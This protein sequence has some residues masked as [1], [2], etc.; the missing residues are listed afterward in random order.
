MKLSAWDLRLA[1]RAFGVASVAALVALLVIV[2][3]DDGASWARRAAMWGAIAPV[4][5]AVGV[6]AA[7]RVA[8]ARGELLA[9]SA[10]GAQ[11]GR[12]QAGA[13]VGGVVLALAGPVVLSSGFAD[14]SAL[15]PEPIEARAWVESDAPGEGGASLP[16]PRSLLE[17]TMGVRVERG[18][19]VTFLDEGAAPPVGAALQ[20]RTLASSSSR[21]AI[22]ATF[23]VALCAFACPIWVAV[24]SS[25]LRKAIVGLI[26]VFALIAAF[27]AVAAE[28]AS[29]TFALLLASPSLLLADALVA[30]Y[31]SRLRG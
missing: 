23:A 15:F 24:R 28:R 20:R 2:T 22:A 14:Q 12:A 29:A 27:Q 21:A 1:A 13:V 4:A 25:L 31:R 19:R 26:A 18:G 17:I 9:L 6:I 30:R 7:L 5:G 8:S 10:I 11:P 16:A 3:T